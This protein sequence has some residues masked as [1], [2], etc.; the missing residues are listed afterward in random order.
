MAPHRSNEEIRG[1]NGHGAPDRFRP[2]D[3]V[4]Q[5]P[6]DVAEARGSAEPSRSLVETMGA[7]L[8]ELRTSG[9]L[10]LSFAELEER[11][12]DRRRMLAVGGL[13]DEGRV[14]IRDGRVRMSA[15]QRD[16]ERF[17]SESVVSTEAQV[18][19]EKR[20]SQL[21]TEIE[22]ATNALAGVRA[23][24]CQREVADVVGLARN[25]MLDIDEAHAALVVLAEAL[26]PQSREDHTSP[27][28]DGGA[29]R[30]PRLLWRRV[31]M[32]KTLSFEIGFGTPRAAYAL[33]MADAAWIASY[34]HV[35]PA[36][37]VARVLLGDGTIVRC[38]VLGSA[39]DGGYVLSSPGT[40]RILVDA[41]GRA[42]GGE[43]FRLHP[44]DLALLRGESAA[45]PSTKVE[46]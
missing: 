7:V 30:I 3:F 46:G 36:I 45:L 12:A 37:A 19:L 42:R 29:R 43:P 5:P 14:V 32:L 33:G 40:G 17:T 2:S 22:L 27:A 28:D 41:E 4:A 15:A 20:V 13:R 23:G 21:E 34:G 10:G 16:V 11:I 24:L 18:A 35:E 8:H 25:R 26:A 6:Q 39:R 9:P 38:L 31:E 1:G 44:D